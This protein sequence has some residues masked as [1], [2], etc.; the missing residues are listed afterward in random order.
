MRFGM[1]L[2]KK[3]SK[4]KTSK[5]TFFFWVFLF[6][7]FENCQKNKPPSPREKQILFAREGGAYSS[8]LGIIGFHCRYPFQITA[9]S[10]FLLET[11]ETLTKNF[12]PDNPPLFFQKIGQEGGGAYLQWNPLIF[13]SHFQHTHTHTKKKR[14]MY[15]FCFFLYWDSDWCNWYC[16]CTDWRICWSSNNWWQLHCEQCELYLLFMGTRSCWI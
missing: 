7:L 14:L 11:P 15:I 9:L 8:F 10:F 2:T 13:C 3:N 6:F 5:K 1:T 16:W 4:I 12:R